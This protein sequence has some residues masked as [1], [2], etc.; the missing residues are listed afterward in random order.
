MAR[1]KS[2]YRE[3]ARTVTPSIEAESVVC[4]VRDLIAHIRSMRKPAAKILMKK[5]AGVY[6]AANF[7]REDLDCLG[8]ANLYDADL[9]KSIM[10][11]IGYEQ[12]IEAKTHDQLEREFSR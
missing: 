5:M 12:G 8:Y 10:E 3:L 1:S 6:A 7:G 11:Y 2:K 9:C 4:R